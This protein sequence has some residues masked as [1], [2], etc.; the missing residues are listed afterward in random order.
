MSSF[1]FF[2][3]VVCAQW[4]EMSV[5]ESVSWRWLLDRRCPNEYTLPADCIVLLDR[6]DVQMSDR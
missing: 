2:E 6:S 3:F 4:M 5:L 1:S